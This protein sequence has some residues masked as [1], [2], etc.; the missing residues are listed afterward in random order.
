VIEDSVT[1]IDQQV[2]TSMAADVPN[3][4]EW[5]VSRAGMVAA[6]LSRLPRYQFGRLKLNPNAAPC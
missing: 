5:K 1:A 2:A 4:T 3:V 6:T